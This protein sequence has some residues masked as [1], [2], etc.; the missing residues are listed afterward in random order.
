MIRHVSSDHGGTGEWRAVRKGSIH[1]YRSSLSTTPTPGSRALSGTVGLTAIVH[2]AIAFAF[3]AADV[4]FGKVDGWGVIGSLIE[5]DPARRIKSVLRAKIISACS[6]T[7]WWLQFDIPSPASR[8][9]A[10]NESP[11]SLAPLLG[12]LIRLACPNKPPNVLSKD[13]TG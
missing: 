8:S 9:L 6:M 3:S 13:M 11:T 12:G 1:I 7:R 5:Y 10:Q 4:L 2:L